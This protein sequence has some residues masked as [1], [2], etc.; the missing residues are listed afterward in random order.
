MA[1]STSTESYSTVLYRTVHNCQ[2]IAVE[3]SMVQYCT[4]NYSTLQYSKVQT[5]HI[6]TL[7]Y[8]TVQYRTLQKST[9]YLSSSP[10]F[11]KITVVSGEDR[12]GYWWMDITMDGWTVVWINEQ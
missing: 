2:Y 1:P 3:T 8:F 12:Q 4:L 5:V 10:M 11:H 7:Q 9:I 6:S